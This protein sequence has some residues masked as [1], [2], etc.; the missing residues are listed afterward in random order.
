MIPAVADKISDMK[1]NM[2]RT[3]WWSFIE[4]GSL[5]AKLVDSALWES[6]ELSLFEHLL[7]KW[8]NL[9]T[10]NNC[11]LDQFMNHLLLLSPLKG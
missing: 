1:M 2:N 8:E 5:P 10:F 9:N 6:V 11:F 4:K 7:S 3:E